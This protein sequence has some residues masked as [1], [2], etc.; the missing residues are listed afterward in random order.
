MGKKERNGR[1]WKEAEELLTNCNLPA[2]FEQKV[3]VI[4]FGVFPAIH[5][6]ENEFKSPSS[7]V[8]FFYGQQLI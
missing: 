2:Q 5:R 3:C 4:R 8:A 7:E 6:V 1:N